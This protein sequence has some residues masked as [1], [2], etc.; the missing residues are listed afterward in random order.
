YYR[1]KRVAVLNKGEVIFDVAHDPE[2]PFIVDSGHAQITVLGTYFAVNRLNQLVR[3]SVDHGRVSVE[4]HHPDG[5]LRFEPLILS[6]GEVA[7]VEAGNRP[8]KVNRNAQDAFG[9]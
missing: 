6:D 4:A 5:N 8:V 9:F 1:D 2:R 3:I 7:E